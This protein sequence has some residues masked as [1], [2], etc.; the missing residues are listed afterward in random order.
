MSYRFAEMATGENFKRVAM[1][2]DLYAPATERGSVVGMSPGAHS[3][4]R[5]R[6]TNFQL[7]LMHIGFSIAH[8]TIG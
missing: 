1:A 7:T 8:V 6:D 4:I 3:F 5:G 2:L